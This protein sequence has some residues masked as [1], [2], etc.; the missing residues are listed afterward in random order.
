[1]PLPFTIYLNPPNILVQPTNSLMGLIT[2]DNFGTFG[3]VVE[4]N[5]ATI[6]FSVGDIVFYNIFITS[7]INIE[8]L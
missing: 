4:T 2:E 6:S 1:M 7:I 3:E 5:I 8:H